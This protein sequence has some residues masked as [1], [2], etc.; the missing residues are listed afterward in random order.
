MANLPKP[1]NKRSRRTTSSGPEFRALEV[2]AVPQPPLPARDRPWSAETL[3]FWDELGT[4]SIAPELSAVEWRILMLAAVAYEAIWSDGALT[5]VDTLLN[6]MGRFPFT[7]RDR[8]TLR[9]TA[10]TG[11]QMEAKARAQGQRE[12]VAGR[13][14]AGLRAVDTTAGGQA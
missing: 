2:V 7:P 1:A 6:L 14:Y 12:H 9:I 3:R 10:L 4:S 13:N 11:E 5:R 8:Q